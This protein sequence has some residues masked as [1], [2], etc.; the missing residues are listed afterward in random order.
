MAVNLRPW[1]TP[2]SG[3]QPAFRS[4][5]LNQG[6]NSGNGRI[7]SPIT[8][9]GGWTMALRDYHLILGVL[10]TETARVLQMTFGDI[11]KQLRVDRLSDSVT[12]ESQT[13]VVCC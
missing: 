13:L 7:D 2:G 10:C 9:G 1:F 11:G 4:K 3:N 8:R 12:V 6:A 5:H